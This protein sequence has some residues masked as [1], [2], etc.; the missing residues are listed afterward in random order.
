MTTPSPGPWRVHPAARDMLDVVRNVA[1][2]DDAWLDHA[3]PRLLRE[4]IR[5]IR[6]EA[7]AAIASNQRGVTL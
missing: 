4:A 3:H 7:R 2:I 5:Q 6:D 1:G